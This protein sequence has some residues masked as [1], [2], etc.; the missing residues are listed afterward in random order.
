MNSNLGARERMHV[1]D[2]ASSSALLEEFSI[3]NRKVIKMSFRGS[4]R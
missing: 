4:T 1:K 2:P 3:R